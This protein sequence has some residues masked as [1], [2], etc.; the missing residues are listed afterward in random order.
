MLIALKQLFIKSDK[1]GGKHTENIEILKG[2]N[3]YNAKSDN[4]CNTFI[5]DKKM[6]LEEFGKL[7][8][9]QASK[10]YLKKNKYMVNALNKY[11]LVGMMINVSN[12][13]YDCKKLVKYFIKLSNK[14]LLH[15]IKFYFIA[16]NSPYFEDVI[17][18][19]KALYI[20]EKEERYRFIYDIVCADLD[21]KFEQCQF[22]DFKN[23][24]CIANRTHK[25]DFEQMGCCHS[26]E[27]NS[28]FSTKL[29]K[30]I[31]VCKYLK[32]K[33][34]TTQNISCKL[35]TCG[36]LRKKKIRFDS[37]KILLLDCFFS[38]R[39]H[40]IIR[41]NFFKSKEEII[42]KLMEEN[43]ECYIWY[44]FRRKFLI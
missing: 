28:L 38:Y 34:C 1:K 44:L 4:V 24:K 18:C 17:S 29:L 20:K 33:K 42:K 22:C 12:R 5:F 14:N 40:D 7:Q 21:K 8:A 11:E 27:L 30:N 23:D 35:F 32:D 41:Y 16:N 15:K 36:Y 13:Y 43:H 3:E 26:F 2:Y 19:L 37:H 31:K 25:I 10:T 6:S 9:K 39:Q